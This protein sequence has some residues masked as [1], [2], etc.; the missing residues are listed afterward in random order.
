MHKSGIVHDDVLQ[1]DVVGGATAR[2]L[3]L[4]N[5]RGGRL[6]VKVPLKSQ[7]AEKKPS[8]PFRAGGPARTRPVAFPPPRAVAPR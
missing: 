4:H 2:R 7:G 5:D 1:A 8:S 6:T 3:S